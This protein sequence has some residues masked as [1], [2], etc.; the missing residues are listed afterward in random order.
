MFDI[1]GNVRE[2]VGSCGVAGKL[3]AGC[4]EHG[5]RGRGWLSSADKESVTR[6]DSHAEDV[7]TNSLGFRVVRELSR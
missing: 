6:A 5:I 4:R 7:A 2:W 3:A 1:D